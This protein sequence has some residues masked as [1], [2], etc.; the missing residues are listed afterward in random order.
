MRIPRV[1]ISGPI[2]KGDR[3]KNY[4]RAV[5]AERTLMLAGFA[6]LNPMRSMTLPHAWSADMPHEL[7]L[8]ADLPWVEVADAVLRLPGESEG[9]D[10]EC[11]Y[12]EAKGIPVFSSMFDL[13]KH[14]GKTVKGTGVDHA[15]PSR[16][17]GSADYVVVDSPLPVTKDTNP[18]DAIGSKKSPLSVL[19]LPV[20]FEAGIVML[21]GAAKYGRHNYRAIGVRA[22][23]YYD[24][25]MRH[26]SQ[27]WEGEDVDGESGVSHLAHAICCL[28]IVRDSAIRGMLTDD[29]PPKTDSG[30]MQR[31]NELAAKVCSKYPDAKPPFTAA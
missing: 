19:P 27:W 11:E 5:E 8:Q 18:K 14:Y 31:F 25:A 22:S 4:T 6:P 26:L 24:A 17:D 13:F 3:L 2:T 20:L 16:S 9:A 12:A 7:W 28:A 29:R 30:W 1:Y 21:L 10:E 23:V 15:A